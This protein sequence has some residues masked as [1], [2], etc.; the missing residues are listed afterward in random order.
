MKQ[1]SQWLAFGKKLAK[2]HNIA[3]IIKKISG[4]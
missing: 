3:I 2:L 1:R 4:E